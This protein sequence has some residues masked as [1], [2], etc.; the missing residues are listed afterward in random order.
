[1]VIGDKSDLVQEMVSL[2]LGLSGTSREGRV[3]WI[4]RWWAGVG[5]LDEEKATNLAVLNY[6]H[7]KTIDN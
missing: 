2:C 7:D 5:A 6:T 1:M 4:G 3:R